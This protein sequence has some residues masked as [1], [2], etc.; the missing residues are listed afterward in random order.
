MTLLQ[1][2]EPAARPAA[3]AAQKLALGIDLGTTNSL[4][5]VIGKDGKPAALGAPPL[6]PSVVYYAADG[7]ILVGDAARRMRRDFPQDVISSAKRLMGR[8]AA[9]V[10][11]AYQ[12]DYVSGAEGM[13]V[14]RTAAGEKSPVEVSAEILKFLR[15]CAED[16]TGKT[17]DGAVITV[18]AYFDEAQRQA[19][20]DAARIAGLKV[21]RLLGEPTAAAVAYGLDCAEEGDY[22][23]YDLGGGTFDV[24][25]L[26]MQKGVFTVL[27]TGGD[28]ALGGDDYDRVLAS[29][30]REKTG[31]RDLS[32]GDL[33][34]LAAA[35]RDAKEILSAA[36][37][38]VLR[39]QLSGGE[40]TCEIGAAEFFAAA[41]ALT[42]KTIACCKNALHDANI[43]SADI[44]RAVL[45][46][47]ATRMP[48][49]KNA[50]RDFLGREPFSELNPDEVVA[51][52][53]AAQAD[54]LAG[55]RR[56]DDWLLLDVI[57]LSLGLETMGGLAE[58]IIPRNTVIPIQKSQEFTTHQ[59]GQTAMSLHVVQGEREL[60]RDCRSLARFDLSG[61]PPLAAGLARVRVSFQVDA[62][63]LLSVSAEERETGARAEVAVKPTYGLDE[64]KILEMLHDSF[65]GAEKD[66]AMRKLL[67]SRQDGEAMLHAVQ[68][69]TTDA[70]DLLPAEEKEAIEN[71]AAKLQKALKGEDRNAIDAAAKALN[72]ASENF[73]ARKMN[74]DIKRALAG[75]KIE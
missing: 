31:A 43:N 7:T 58:K 4:V 67:E 12:Y 9:D 15:R 50:L 18:P 30:A 23:V 20:K 28:A 60:T 45:V 17:A 73:A 66:A 51:L 46:G 44:K 34:L 39:A 47:G 41:A 25:V 36:D 37:S 63:G 3:P 49:V 24:S 74:A 19:T 26:R 6:A 13:A 27:A 48:A 38:A 69:A 29:L 53:A 21:Y 59:D 71:A 56:G 55:N 5:A 40:M 68:N 35:A 70:G 33:L 57:P 22:L 54:L 42:E 1:I 2:Q 62:D 11:G 32:N 75:K 72:A 16:I 61:I 10:R 52:G 8:A 64:K 65:S 14:V